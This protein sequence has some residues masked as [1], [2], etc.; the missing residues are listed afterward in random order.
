MLVCMVNLQEGANIQS[1]LHSF[2]HVIFF[3]GALTSIWKDSEI[4]ALDLSM[5]HGQ[6]WIHFSALAQPDDTSLHL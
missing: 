5:P 1:F 2:E 3:K 6:F 4:L